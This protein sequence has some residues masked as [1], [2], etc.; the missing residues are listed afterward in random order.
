MKKLLLL[1]LIAIPFSAQAQTPGAQPE[2]CVTSPSQTANYNQLCISAS[3]SGGVVSVTNFGSATGGLS[4][5]QNGAGVIGFFT[6]LSF[7]VDSLPNYLIG[8]RTADLNFAAASDGSTAHE[9]NFGTPLNTTAGLNSIENRFNIRSGAAQGLSIINSFESIS[10]P[11]ATSFPGPD[12][13]NPGIGSFQGATTAV[14]TGSITGAVLTVTGV[15]SGSIALG[16]YLTDAGHLIPGGVWVVSNG[17][18]SGGLGTYNLSVTL[19][20]PVGS[21]II[22]VTSPPLLELKGGRLGG[23]FIGSGPFGIGTSAPTNMLTVIGDG[24]AA[25]LAQVIIKGATSGSKQLFYGFDTVSNYGFIQ[26]VFQSVG[27]E[28]LVLSQFGGGVSIGTTTAPAA[29]GLL[30]VGTVQSNTGFNING[31]AG[32]SCTVNTP[33]HLTVVNGIVTLCN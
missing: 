31:T 26:A 18:G 24:T 4:F 19:G 33:A 13:Y 8:S 30:V 28:P 21:E 3:A 20:S 25:G 29:N 14:V 10:F 15:T 2:F 23:A 12:Q 9:I 1:T 17:T 22:T 16:N 5:A 11:F 27:F 32:A 7:G 6:G